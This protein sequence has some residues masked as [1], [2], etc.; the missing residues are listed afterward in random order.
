MA[1]AR[2]GIGRHDLIVV[3]AGI[4][5][6]AHALAARRRGL[7]VAVVD[8]EA[9]AIGASVRN[10]GFVTVTGQQ[11]GDCWRRAMRS[12]DI[13]LEVAPAAGIAVE[14]RGLLVAV[15]RP[16]AMAVLEAFRGT[17]MGADC[18]LLGPAALAAAHGAI[19]A[20]GP[21]AGGL[22]S[23]HEIRV[24]SRTAIPRLAAWLA[25][26]MGAAFHRR[27]L[28]RAVEPGRVETTAG[29]LMAPRIVVCPGDDLLG[30]F[31]E[32]IAAAGITR[33]RLQ[34]LK[35]AP[36]DPGYRLPGSVMSDLSL[37]RY[38]GWADLP[39]A[40]ALRVRLQAEQAAHLAE[41]IHLIAVQGADGGLVVGDSH[42][43]EWTPRPFAEAVVEDLILDEMHRTLRLPGARVVE[44]WTGTYA[45]LPDRLM[46]R[47][48]PGDGIR[49]VIV[50]SGTGASTAF[51]IAEETLAEL[52]ED[53]A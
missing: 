22:W 52:C 47:E 44:R 13:W 42:H 27:T 33:C 17:A 24:E 10:F 11:A 14:H 19:L 53:P 7:S 39:E 41:G 30:L 16:E 31:P 48:A 40:A 21:F 2:A 26:P 1:M 51:A 25:G 50:T 32:R 18:S 8:R 3:G 20:G 36:G 29:T 49:L 34:M 12:R 6:L 35:L 23:P 28:V 15:R 5:G 4:V 37:V 46:L 9:E 38:L 43:Y 45:S